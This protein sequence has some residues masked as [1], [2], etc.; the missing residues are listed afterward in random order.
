M[1]RDKIVASKTSPE[2]PTTSIYH[3]LASLVIALLLS[4]L[5]DARGIVHAGNG[6]PD[7]FARKATLAVGNAALRVD[8]FAHLTAPWDDLQAALGRKTQPAAAPLLATGAG[9]P[10]ASASAGYSPATASRADAVV[11]S[12][13]HHSAA[14]VVT[15]FHPMRPSPGRARRAPA[16]RTAA[17]RAVLPRPVRVPT[18]RNPLRLLVTGDSLSGYLGPELVDEASRVGPVQGFV[19]THDGTGLTRPDF[20]DWS[21]VA[22]QQVAAHHPDVVVVLIGGNDFQNM[23]LPGG[24]FFLAGSPNW[25]QEYARRAAICMRVW[26]QQGPHRVYWLSMPPSRDS[27]WARVD[28][29]I[30]AALRRA[31]SQVPGAEYLDILGPVTDHGRY[32]D[33]VNVNGQPVLVREPDGVHLNFTGSTLVAHEVLAVIEREWH[34]GSRS[35][36]AASRARGRGRPV[37][38]LRAR[39]RP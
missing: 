22:Q 31:A 8:A 35:K 7:G 38:L 18:P 4:M 9:Y 17:P 26:S 13:S 36:P 32:A 19:E 23:T 12:P 2:S 28:F 30:N 20:V 10:P 33:F 37:L 29:Q 34:L 25:T 11:P 3:V 27:G 15:T 21:V 39:R 6:M 5:L 14:S 24:K 1:L 16:H